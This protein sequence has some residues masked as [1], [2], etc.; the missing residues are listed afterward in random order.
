MK[1]ST[2]LIIVLAVLA[3]ILSSVAAYILITRSQKE[4]KSSKEKKERTVDEDEDEEITEIKSL[5][6]KIYDSENKK[7]TEY[8]VNGTFGSCELYV[9]EQTG[10]GKQIKHQAIVDK[11]NM[12]KYLNECRVLSWDGIMTDK[13][14]SYFEFNAK[15]NGRE[16]SAEGAYE[17]RPEEMDKMTFMLMTWATIQT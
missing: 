16:L 3:V 11:T 4:D 13:T 5:Y 17:D 6:I 2:V 15:L 7:T 1:K 12:L 9:Y 14:D 10:R 8:E